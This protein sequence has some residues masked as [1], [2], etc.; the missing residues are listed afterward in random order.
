MEGRVAGECSPSRNC[1]QNQVTWARCHL[2]GLASGIDWTS[3]SSGDSG[4]A[5]R[6]VSSRTV[7][8][9]SPAPGAARAILAGFGGRNGGAWGRD[10]NVWL[11][12]WFSSRRTPVWERTLLSPD[13]FRRR[14]SVDRAPRRL[15]KGR[16]ATKWIRRAAGRYHPGHAAAGAIAWLAAWHPFGHLIGV[17]NA[18]RLHIC[19]TERRPMA[20]SSRTLPQ[21]KAQ[22]RDHE[23]RAIHRQRSEVQRRRAVHEGH[24][25]VS[26]V[27]I[28][29]PGGPDSRSR[30]RR[31]QGPER[32]RI[33]PNCATASRPI[34]TGRPFPSF[35]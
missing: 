35:T 25:A 12:G 19:V 30:R 16:P 33:R 28:F 8:K 9:A 14:M 17:R 1:S 27:R 18:F 22:G 10:A 7:R 26:A 4:A 32:A 24:A 3:W 13:R 11:G 2:A 6:S 15:L 21:G 31:L 5:R 34:R 20:A 29:G 23:H